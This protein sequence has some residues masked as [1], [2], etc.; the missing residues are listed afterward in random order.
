MCSS[1]QF[2]NAEH[3][4][5]KYVFFLPVVCHILLLV[6]E[7]EVENPPPLLV[8]DQSLSPVLD[9]WKNFFPSGRP[10]ASEWKP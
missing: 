4:V 7:T 8:S 1:L 6:R 5:K 3:A 10:A 2:P 9:R